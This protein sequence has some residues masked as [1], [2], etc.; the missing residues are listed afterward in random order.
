MHCAHAAKRRV[1]SLMNRGLSN[2]EWLGDFNGRGSIKEQTVRVTA[3]IRMSAKNDIQGTL[4]ARSRRPS[5][6]VCRSVTTLMSDRRA[7]WGRCLQA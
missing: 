2:S 7:G 4:A 1:F 6:G 3:E 5:A